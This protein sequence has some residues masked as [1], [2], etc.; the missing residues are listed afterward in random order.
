M[1][2]RETRETSDDSSDDLS[3]WSGTSGTKNQVDHLHGINDSDPPFFDTDTR[4]G[5]GPA[6]IPRHCRPN[7]V[8]MPPT[9]RGLYKSLEERASA[10][11]SKRSH[12][13]SSR[14]LF[15]FLHECTGP[16]WAFL[17]Y[18]QTHSLLYTGHTSRKTESSL[19]ARL[20]AARQRRRVQPTGNKER[21]KE[22]SKDRKE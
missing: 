9:C 3:H 6:C 16:Q 17:T 10:S 4:G 2:S 21:K 13:R 5:G 22:Y 8:K 12:P 1:F 20:E 18:T 11:F 15:L 14:K 7:F 19:C